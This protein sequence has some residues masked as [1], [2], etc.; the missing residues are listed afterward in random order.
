[1]PREGLLQTTT[2]LEK[3]R[4]QALDTA[5][6]C[7]Q[8]LKNLGASEVFIC[9]SLAGETPWHWH[10]D[11]D[12]AILGLSQA[13]VW[14]AHTAI[15]NLVP[16]W[17]EVDLIPLEFVPD[18][19]RDRILSRV[20]MVNN[21]YSAL[22]LR[23]DDEMNSLAITVNTLSELLRQQE[24]IPEIALLPALASYVADFYNGCER[25]SERVAVYL[26]GGI[27]Q[28]Q[29]W[30]LELLKLMA[31]PGGSDRPSLW[32][33]ALLLEL[34][35][36]RKFRHLTRH[37]YKVELDSDR[38]IALGQ[39]VEVV[40]DKIKTAVNNFTQWLDEKGGEVD[41]SE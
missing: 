36:Y 34:S 32:T 10:S 20:S 24:T 28:V 12:L 39:E 19:L 8:V 4:S 27:P 11:L 21:K 6:L 16:P 18:H 14:N 3:R 22:K 23:I 17:L 41:N 2:E 30:H 33:G 9:G 7:M 37:I 31:E 15:E 38:V 40:F 29:D 35:E 13:Q 26:D 1:M 25:I 5:E